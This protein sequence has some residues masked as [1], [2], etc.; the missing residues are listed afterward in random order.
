MAPLATVTAESS[1][2][3]PVTVKVPALT[4]VAPLAVRLLLTVSTPLPA[5]V[6]LAPA[7]STSAPRVLASVLV[8][9]RVPALTSVTSALRA[10]A[11]P[12]TLSDESAPVLPTVP[13]RVTL[14][15][16]ALTVRLRAVLSEL[17]V[18]LKVIG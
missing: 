4:V 13:D 17:M 3:E 10:S 14:P 5:L 9:D 1:L 6:K 12:L 11:A 16:P 8:S 2:N 18:L 7:P 15:V